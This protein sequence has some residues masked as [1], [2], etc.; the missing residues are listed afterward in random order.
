VQLCEAKTDCDK[1]QK[2]TKS[3]TEHDRVSKLEIETLTASPK[4]KNAMEG[5]AETVFSLSFF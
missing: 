1:N 4:S 3:V 2:Q 5:L